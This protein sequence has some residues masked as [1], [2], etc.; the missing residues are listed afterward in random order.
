M[1]GHEQYRDET[2]ITQTING[3]HNI[4]PRI[5]ETLKQYFRG[6]QHVYNTGHHSWMKKTPQRATD[7]HNTNERNNTDIHNTT[8]GTHTHNGNNE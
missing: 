8:I 1:G 5:R 6:C 2:D 3:T 4:T 7:T